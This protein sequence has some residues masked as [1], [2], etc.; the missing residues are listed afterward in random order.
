MDATLRC[1]SEDI[2]NVTNS[3]EGGTEEWSLPDEGAALAYV[4]EQEEVDEQAFSMNR[5]LGEPLGLYLFD[6]YCREETPSASPAVGFLVDCEKLLRS[7]SHAE[8]SEMFLHIG[9]TYLT[10]NEAAMGPLDL[11]PLRAGTFAISPVQQDE[12]EVRYLCKVGLKD[13][14]FAPPKLGRG[15]TLRRMQTSGRGLSDF[16]QR[17]SNTK[18]KRSQIAPMLTMRVK[19]MIPLRGSVLEGLQRLGARHPDEVWKAED[20]DDRLETLLGA[21]A[22]IVEALQRG[23]YDKFRASRH[24]AQLAQFLMMQKG[25][26]RYEDFDVLRIIGRGGFGSVH[27]CKRKTTGHMYALKGMSKKRIAQ[28]GLQICANEKAALMAI[29]SPFVVSLA[30][31]FTTEDDVFLVLDLATG[32]DLALLL[33]K[34]EGG[35]L[36]CA[37]V[38]YY[39]FRMA[40]GLQHI[41]AAGFVYRNCKPENVL[42]DSEGRTR[43]SD[44]GLAVQVTDDLHGEAGTCGYM[45]PEM[46]QTDAAGHHLRYNAAV[47]WF[48]FGCTVFELLCGTSPFRT[49]P[50]LELGVRKATQEMQVS[51]PAH[52]TRDFG[53]EFKNFSNRLLA[54][55]PA[56]RLGAHGADEVLAHEWFESLDRSAVR[57][58]RAPPPY[59][60]SDV[61]VNAESQAEFE[62]ISGDVAG[63]DSP[64]F[65]KW[66]WT[67]PMAFQGEVYPTLTLRP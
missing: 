56:E 13:P 37:E 45:A 30:Y 57:A 46:M 32:G 4:A 54:K 50:A 63:T 31:S 42:V 28:Q 60:P 66:A 22:V 39:A 47:D 25:A 11:A 24:F 44:F 67:N 21:K 18:G 15:A 55:L 48:G 64:V 34:R 12:A 62:E 5:I 49:Q 52:T 58:D 9:Q 33:S 19:A 29:H 26:V 27:A 65:Q 3:D 51:Y 16:E 20:D 36:P 14:P 6:K 41:H 10:Q 1:V 59:V 61:H 38:K 7:N 40:L 23:C 43:I 8:R 35:V 17:P 53:F 2:E